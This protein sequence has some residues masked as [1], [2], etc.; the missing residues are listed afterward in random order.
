MIADPNAG[1]P[2]N[3][4]AWWRSF[5]GLA[6]CVI[7]PSTA[8]FKKLGLPMLTAYVAIAAV[9]LW[10]ALVWIAPRLDRMLT[11]RISLA[12]LSF[13]LVLVFG[14][15][16]RIHPRIDTQGF[17]L[18][19]HSFGASDNDDA[20]D[21]AIT[22]VLEG[23]YP[24]RARTFLN[25]PIT[26]MPGALL[27]AFPFYLL[28]DSAVQNVFWLAVFFGAV[29]IFYRSAFTAAVLAVLALILSPNV[30]YHVLLGGDYIANAIYVLTFSALLIESARKQ[31]TFWR[32]AAW[33]ALLGMGLSSRLNFVLILPLVFFGLLKST[34]PERTGLLCA[35]VLGTFGAITLP[36]YLYDPSGFSPLHTVDKLSVFGA[37]RWA[38]LALPAAGAAL[39]LALALRKGAFELPVFMRD[40]FAVQ[41]FVIVGGFLLA[42]IHRKELDL[43]YS[44]F[45]VLFL[46]PGLF[47]FGPAS[48]RGS[49]GEMR[50]TP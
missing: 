22:E 6:F 44:H 45:A 4:G 20:I 29:A 34:S 21:L 35:I 39:A 48:L 49:A 19:G 37:Y 16:V 10:L 7:F 5:A 1:N 26:P 8:I 17:R 36:F 32:S 31:E 33:A 13:M 15:Y 2:R 40:V 12:V 25:N 18:A 30:V 3:R 43:V 46:F 47:A 23:R 11:P 24:Y 41:A 27:L 42:S 28:G 50:P 14:A 38:P 9:L